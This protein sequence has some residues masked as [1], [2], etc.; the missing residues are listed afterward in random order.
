MSR[1]GT[2]PT[3]RWST[4]RRERSRATSWSASA[5]GASR[6]S[7]TRR[8]STWRTAM[9][10]TSRS[11]MSPQA[12]RPCRSRSGGSHGVSPLTTRLI[13]AAWLWL[14][15]AGAALAQG[16]APSLASERVVIGYVEV[17]GD[18]RYEPIT[19]YGRLVLKSRERPFT[20]AEVA[21]D[22]AQ[23]A[24]RVLKIEFALERISVKSADAV[25]AAVREAHEAR[26]LRFFIVDAP[27]EAFGPLATATRGRDL[28]LFNATAADDELRR[29]LCAPQIVHTLPSLAMRMDAL[30][31]YLVSRKWRDVLIF[32]GPDKADATNTKAFL[33]SL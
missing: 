5:R 23:A 8:R 22:E 2:R 15:L 9:A 20:G 33:A 24:S 4:S 18:K 6:C 19:A 1:S 17:E 14:G 26:G 11:A 13:A 32:E 27:A 31:Q 29:T 10:P 7:A 12:G 28:L 30:A 3:S 25:A 21:I 16:A